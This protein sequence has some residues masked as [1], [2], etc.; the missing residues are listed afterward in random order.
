MEDIYEEDEYSEEI[1]EDLKNE[2]L[3]T[4]IYEYCQNYHLPLF[5]H[6]DTFNK[7]LKLNE[8]V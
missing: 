6:P 3:F 8:R 1:V 2:H 5:N 7:F 4:E